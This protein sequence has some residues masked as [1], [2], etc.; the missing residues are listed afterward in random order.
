MYRDWWEGSLGGR[1][2]VFPVNYV[3]EIRDVTA[4]ELRH[5]AGMEREIH[6][7]VDHLE[8]L[9]DLLDVGDIGD[10]ATSLYQSVLAQS[11]LLIEL[12]ETYAQREGESIMR[13]REIQG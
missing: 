3:E 13:Q 7:E 10:E 4:P 5:Q 2:G 8:R 12:I 11:P 1:T 9:L 6:S